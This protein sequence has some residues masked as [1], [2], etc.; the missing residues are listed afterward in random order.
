MASARAVAYAGGP[1]TERVEPERGR[2]P[3]RAAARDALALALLLGVQAFLV[4]RFWFLLDDAYISF[5]FAR[6]WAGGH[7]LRFNL[8]DAPVEGYTNFALVAIGAAIERAGL[9]IEAW[10]PAV[11][12]GAG[13][14][15]TVGTYRAIR[16][17]LGV[18]A[19]V[20]ALATALLACSAQYA[21]WSTSGLETMLFALAMFATFER[22][23]LAPGGV[24]VVSGA[25]WALLLALTRAE[26]IYW[27]VP[28]VAL[29]AL[30]RRARG[31]PAARPLAAFAA[32]VALPYGAYFAWRLATFGHP[33][34]MTAYSKVR[35]SLAGLERGFDYVASQVC[36]SPTLLVV[37]PGLVAA[38][39]PGRRALALPAAAMSLGLSA[40]SVLVGGDFMTFGRFLVPAL[41]FDALL[42][43]C[44]L[45]DLRARGRA[46]LVLAGGLAAGLAAL[47]GWNLHVVPRS[48]LQRFHF[49]LNVETAESEYEQWREQ[50]W[51]GI[52]WS[53][54]GRALHELTGP[55]DAIV[56]GAVGAVGY[57]SG[58]HIY[59]R[60]GLVT[61]EVGLMPSPP[62]DELRTPGHDHGV[63]ASWFVAQGYRPEI[64]ESRILRLGPDEPLARLERW[65]DDLRADPYLGPRYVFEFHELRAPG[66]EQPD[67]RPYYVIV[68]RRIHEGVQPADAWRTADETLERFARTREAPLLRVAPPE[69]PAHGE[70]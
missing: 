35:P 2:R 53:V 23:V 8:A 57:W 32:L 42:W 46:A 27:I 4:H 64:V 6:N 41:P 5:H 70:E 16:A 11:T 20:A 69:R 51:N 1:L 55:D 9:S 40:W 26:G 52:R 37:L 50:R 67:A 47:P 43:G 30:S 14:L 44:V 68:W 17:R 29:T 19:L 45:A 34:P 66:Q 63:T 12:A 56:T 60:H 59:D 10:I 31:Q 28:L 7:G 39:R 33:F 58:R 38:L 49:R 61:A 25:A 62:Q 48:V 22:L 3:P 15:L 65:R 18:D 13:A 36:T 24:A 21:V 54:L